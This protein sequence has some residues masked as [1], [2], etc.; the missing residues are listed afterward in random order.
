MLY[1]FWIHD[2]DTIITPKI[3]SLETKVD[4]KSKVTA[5]EIGNGTFCFNIAWLQ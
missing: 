5:R 2:Y 3:V 4:Q 1:P